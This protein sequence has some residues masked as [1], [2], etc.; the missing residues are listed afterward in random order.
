MSFD[1]EWSELRSQAAQ[2]QPAQMRLNHADDGSGGRGLPSGGGSAQP[3][4]SVKSDELGKIGH[5]AFLLYDRVMSDGGWAQITTLR[6]S[7]D[8]AEGHLETGAALSK[9]DEVW[10]TK[11]GTLQEACAHISNHLDFSAKSHAKDDAEIAYTMR[12][13]DG[14]R[15]A[16]SK[17]N[18]YFR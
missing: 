17:I 3:D 10:H 5:D 4:L 7:V 6:A 18:K 16:V 11:L 9:A 2:G 12:D 13:V 8:L 14:D 1:E 15:M